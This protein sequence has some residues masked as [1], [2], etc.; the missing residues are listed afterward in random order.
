MHVASHATQD[1][2][3]SLQLHDTRA[4]VLKIQALNSLDTRNTVL[5]IP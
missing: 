2:R 1:A 5:T 4:K 3:R